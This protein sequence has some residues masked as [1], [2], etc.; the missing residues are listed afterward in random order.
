MIYKGMDLKHQIQ[1]H[2]FVDNE[3]LT[4]RLLYYAPNV[5]DEVRMSESSFYT[6]KRLVW[7]YD[8]DLSFISRLNIELEGIAVL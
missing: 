4:K 2:F 8:E 3:F 7:C 1:V 5:G 6:V